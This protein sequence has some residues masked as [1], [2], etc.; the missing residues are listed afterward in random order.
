MPDGLDRAA[1]QA[2]RLHPRAVG[3]TFESRSGH[4]MDVR[5][6]SR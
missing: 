5:S 1:L 6:L 4:S 2:V 3:R